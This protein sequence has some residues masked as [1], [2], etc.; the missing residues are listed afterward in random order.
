MVLKLR[1]PFEIRGKLSTT[2]EQAKR[3]F[4]YIMKPGAKGIVI[5]RDKGKLI[6]RSLMPKRIVETLYQKNFKRKTRVLSGIIRDYRKELIE[7]VWDKN[8]GKYLWGGNKFIGFNMKRLGNTPNWFKLLL[9][10]GELAK[11][12][13]YCNKDCPYPMVKEGKIKFGAKNADSMEIGVGIFDKKELKLYLIPPKRYDNP[14]SIEIES[15][16]FTGL[17][18][19]RINKSLILHIFFKKYDKYSVNKVV[20]LTNG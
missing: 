12:S 7:P 18:N 6:I 16:E 14:E 13:L 1:L 8:K 9:T 10:F 3:M 2:P 17:P 15:S 5:Q 19:D 4:G 20:L 11:P